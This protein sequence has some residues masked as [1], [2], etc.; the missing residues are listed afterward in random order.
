MAL[1]LWVI[2]AQCHCGNLLVLSPTT[3][4]EVAHL[5]QRAWKAHWFSSVLAT[6]EMGLAS[7]CARLKV[8]WYSS[9]MMP[10]GRSVSAASS[11]A[12]GEYF[13]VGVFHVG[14]SQGSAV[15]KVRCK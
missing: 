3:N 4:H 14:Y 10:A 1:C 2:N 5:H 15:F 12:G 6:Y 11:K 7:M 13:S 8:T 9:A